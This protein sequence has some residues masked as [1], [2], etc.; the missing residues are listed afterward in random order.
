M[1]P[2]PLHVSLAS[3]L[4][5]PLCPVDLGP[6]SLEQA[7]FR[8]CGLESWDRVSQ[9]SALSAGWSLAPGLGGGVGGAASAHPTP[10]GPWSRETSVS[11]RCPGRVAVAVML[12]VGTFSEVVVQLC[13]W[14][15]DQ[16]LRNRVSRRR[17][18][19]HEP[20]G[21]L[22]FWGGPGESAEDLSR[23]ATLA[24]LGR[25]SPVCLNRPDLDFKR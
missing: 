9:E 1:G 2:P 25:A 22:G 11:P 24:A 12:P 5:P 13:G 19:S 15:V 4:S 16:F 18:G 3:R 6:S 20:P 17:S 21:L 7:R 10:A 8:R 23:P 14:G